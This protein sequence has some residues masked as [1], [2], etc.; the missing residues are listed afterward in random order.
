MKNPEKPKYNI[1]IFLREMTGMI[2]FHAGYLLLI[3]VLNAF[4]PTVQALAIAE[5]VNRVEG[6]YGGVLEVRMI[7]LP[8]IILL[9]IVIFKQMIPSATNLV[10]ASAQNRLKAVLR[11]RFMRKQAALQYR[12]IEDSESCAL[13]YR[14]CH[15]VE[16]R[17]W[18]GY[19]TV[20]NG[21][22]L[23]VKCAALMSIVMQAS[24]LSGGAILL[25]SVP[26]FTLAYKT[27]RQNYV[28]QKDAVE[29]KR[30]YQYLAGILTD[31]DHAKERAMF[32]YSGQ[33]AK[34]YDRLSEYVNRKEAVIEKKRYANMKSGS[35]TM[36][37][38]AVIIMLLLLPALSSGKLS[39]GLYVGLVT[40]IL[41]LV[42]GMSWNLAGIMQ[43][44]ADLNA[45]LH[46]VDVFLGMEE[47]EDAVAEPSRIPGFQ[48]E[49]IEFR[50]VSFRYPGREEYV[51]KD[52]SFVLQG[53]KC[54]AVVGKNGAGKSTLTKLMTGLYEDYEGHIF[55]NGKDLR[56]YRYGELKWMFSVVFQDFARYALSFRDNIL[57]GNGKDENERFLEQIIERL[58]LDSCV[59]ELPRGL[60]S[61][62][63]KLEKDGVDLSGGQW[64][65]LAIARLLYSEAPINILDEPTAALD[66]RGEAKVYEMFRRV[67]MDE[68]D[69]VEEGHV[70]EEGHAMEEECAM[71]EG[72][73]VEE[74]HAMEEGRAMEE[75][76]AMEEGCAMGEERAMK[77]FTIL[78]T[79]RLG[80]ARM[81]DEILV[82]D[83]GR[84]M[85]QGTHEALA[86]LENGLYKEM[87]ES[88]RCWYET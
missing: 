19:R 53:S 43:G 40:S 20:C 42:Q 7:L 64:Q 41:N 85:E 5:F 32:G 69:A 78:I 81:A 73:A 49:T 13:I 6:A 17:F 9:G 83:Q 18:T 29:V 12:Y 61:Q 36:V 38:L 33:I 86:G 67:T 82:L 11:N 75:G 16:N 3:A 66:P 28:L 31:R 26:L 1:Y 21:I 25:V 74:S 87:F 65:K 46:D 77:K 79:H 80:A 70:M 2:P 15:N 10:N 55:I 72:H 47:K 52:C 51:L 56:D 34:E 88:Q 50:K 84:I 48:V 14:V 62:L 54:Y 76:H 8:L 27:G 71:K 59:Q 35:L 37:V 4:L 60:D 63:G 45:Y 22:E 39:N 58:E 57:V 23:V 68:G 30:R 44:A 24:I